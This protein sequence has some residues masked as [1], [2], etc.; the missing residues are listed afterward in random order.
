MS[1]IQMQE[2][3]DTASKAKPVALVNGVPAYSFEDYAA[4]AAQDNINN[5]SLD[6]TKFNADGTPAKTNVTKV[7]VNVE[8]LYM[9]RYRQVKKTIQ[10]VNDYRCIKAQ[11]SGKIPYKQVPCFVISR[12][13]EGKL[14]LDKTIT[15]SDN[16]FLSDFTHSL[17]RES[18]LEI[19][20]LLKE[21]GITK[22][23][24]AI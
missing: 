23:K 20:P 18:M 2:I 17:D 13:E 7:A 6:L 3:L 1:T 24:I 11:A 9:N 12:N 14:Q 5:V 21:S 4:L 22:D 16:D 15:V 8:N 19:I 10:I